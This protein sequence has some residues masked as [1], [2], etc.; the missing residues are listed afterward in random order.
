M[1]GRIPWLCTSSRSISTRFPPVIHSLIPRCFAPTAYHSP[2]PKETHAD[3]A[4]L[5]RRK[6]AWVHLSRPSAGGQ[7][8]STCL[9]APQALLP[10]S[11]IVVRND[12]PGL[13]VSLDET[14]TPERGSTVR[15]QETDVRERSYPQ[16]RHRPII[17]AA[18]ALLSA[19]P[20]EYDDWRSMPQQL[21][22]ISSG[23]A[24]GISLS[25]SRMGLTAPKAF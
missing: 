10:R 13:R 22:S 20:E 9:V 12:L 8:L 16:G 18:Q 24:P 14:R 6:G 4:W 15:E 5:C 1:P 3:G 7:T 17:E 21:D 25:T 19:W 2:S 11:H 23:C